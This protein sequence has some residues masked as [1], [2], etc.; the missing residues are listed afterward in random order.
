MNVRDL[1][2]D[3]QRDPL[4][5]LIARLQERHDPTNRYLIAYQVAYQHY[6]LAA[7]RMVQENSVARRFM[8]GAYYVRKYG[9]RYTSAQRFVA[10]QYRHIGRFLGHDFFTTII[11][12]RILLDRT[13]SLARYFVPSKAR[14]SFISFNEHRKFYINKDIPGI[15]NTSY[16]EFIKNE[17]SWLNDSLKRFRDRAIVHNE[18]APYAILGQ[19]HGRMDFAFM[20]LLPEDMAEPDKLV[21]NWKVIQLLE[22][23]EHI[24]EFLTTY[25]R[26]ALSSLGYLPRNI[27]KTPRAEPPWM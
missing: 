12:A 7:Q 11:F 3:L 15:T 19:P 9:D 24:T 17:T 20:Y 13:I 21:G 14:P 25:N 22:L 16:A 18:R 5:D 8:N 10:N 26:R 2:R 23:L 6:S 1:T 4:D 27:L